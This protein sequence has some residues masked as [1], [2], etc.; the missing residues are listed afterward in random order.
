MNISNAHGLTITTNEVDIELPKVVYSFIFPNGKRYIGITIN[1]FKK[2][3]VCHWSRAF[4]PKSKMYY[5]KVYCAIRK[6]KEFVIEF[7][8]HGEDLE[9]KEQEFIKLYDT[10]NNGYNLTTG[11]ELKKN[12]SKESRAKISNSLK[13]NI[14]S[15]KGVLMSDEL[16]AFISQKIKEGYKNGRKN[17]NQK[18]VYLYDRDGNLLETFENTVK[19]SKFRGVGYKSIS[20]FCLGQRRDVKGYIWSYKQ[21]DKQQ[22]NEYRR[23]S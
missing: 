20:R 21:L 10:Y 2:R 4:N 22:L 19:A 5:N 15:N 14:P 1:R 11:G 7:L 13:G 16:K 23:L 12:I 9:T 3:L 6:Y 17:P 8:Y 18:T